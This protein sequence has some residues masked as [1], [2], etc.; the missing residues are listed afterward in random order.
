MMTKKGI[1]PFYAAA[2][3][4]HDALK[5]TPVDGFSRFRTIWRDAGERAEDKQP[6]SAEFLSE[7]AIALTEIFNNN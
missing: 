3:K 6:D 1:S 5:E 2:A 4:I 7:F